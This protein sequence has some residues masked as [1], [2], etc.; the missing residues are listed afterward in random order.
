M[1]LNIL[2]GK[3]I[4]AVSGGVDSMVLLD[5]AGK[6]SGLELIVAHFDHGIRE[7]SAKDAGFVEA[8]AKNYNLRF[9]LGQGNLSGN[10]SEEMARAARYD[11]LNGLKQKHEA[12]AVV[13]AHHQD[14]LIETAFLNT[15]RGT[16]PRGLVAILNNPGVLRPFIKV[17]KK[18]ILNYAITSRIDWVEDETNTDDKYLRNY[19]RRTLMS[20]L[21]MRDRQKIL[22]NIQTIDD[23]IGKSQPVIAK[24]SH[25]IIEKDGS[26]DRMAFTA[27][28]GPV[29]K[30][31]LY[32]WLSDQN[33]S[34]VDRKMIDRLDLAL[35]T[36]RAGTACDIKT[37]KSLRL[38]VKKAQITNTL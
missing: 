12:A 33:V 26:I 19:I 15:I 25:K 29:A 9:E 37:G 10:A 20:R 3:Y 4:L 6:K 1:N 24:I 17:P 21:S 28:P 38:S 7:H 31:L 30:E 35:R 32:V 13:T 11:F 27:L 2:P 8:A 36:S 23:S 16:G 14:D 5:L 34:D 22:E 18:D